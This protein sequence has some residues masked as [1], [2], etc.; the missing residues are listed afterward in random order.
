MPNLAIAT[1][2][3]SQLLTNRSQIVNKSSN[4]KLLYI[5]SRGKLDRE[6]VES[7]GL[8]FKSIFTGKLRRYFSWRNFIDPF[9]VIIGFFQ[10]L[11]LLIRF[12]P[13]VVFSKGGFVSVPVVLAAFILRRPIILHESDS[14][15]GLANRI[16]AKLADKICVSFPLCNDQFIFTGNPIRTEIKDGDPKKGYELTGFSKEKP[17]VLI[18][19]GSQG[20]QKINDMIV[21]DFDELKKVFQIIHITGKGKRT[22]IQDESYAQYEYIGDELKHIYTITDVVVGRAGAN[23]LYELAF[24]KKPSILIP[25]KNQDQINNAAYFEKKGASIILGDKNLHDT[26]NALW[27]DPG[28]IKDMKK[29]LEEVAKPDA[30]KEIAEIIINSQ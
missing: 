17:I 8:Q 5:G 16:V 29:S 27:K 11:W 25:L 12:W 14:V 15:M 30:A 28:K 4:V 20:A 6:L 7:A 22:E 1:E 19:G 13:H 18:W 2:L 3:K 23:S 24:M 26:L 9:F 21:K 10:S